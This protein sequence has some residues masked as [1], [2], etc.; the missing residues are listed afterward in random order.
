MCYQGFSTAFSGKCIVIVV[1]P[2]TSNME[3]QCAFMK[4]AGIKAVML[5]S[6]EEDNQAVL[7]QEVEYVFASPEL[8]LGDAAWR[9]M[10]KSAA[11]QMLIKLFAIDEAHLILQW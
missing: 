7:K 6:N 5:G 4:K 9:S 3:E 2:L 11:K 8:L 10:I 1:S